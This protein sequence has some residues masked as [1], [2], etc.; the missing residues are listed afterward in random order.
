[1]IEDKTAKTVE[2]FEEIESFAEVA[3]LT[4]NYVGGGSF[5]AKNVFDICLGYDRGG[6]V[7]L[8]YSEDFELNVKTDYGYQE[9]GGVVSYIVTTGDIKSIVLDAGLTDSDNKIR[10]KLTLEV[11]Q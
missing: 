4:I 11:V 8:K 9:L 7:I 5:H 6:K 3:K 2:I 1:M 10:Q